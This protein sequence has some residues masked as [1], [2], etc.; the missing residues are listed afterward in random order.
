MLSS[1]SRTGKGNHGGNGV[2]GKRVADVVTCSDHDV[3][4]AGRQP[5]FLINFRNEQ[6]ARNRRITAG[7]YDNRIP[8]SE[9]RPD[10]TVREIHGGIPWADDPNNPNG[11]PI[12]AAL[13]S[14]FVDGQ[15]ASR[16][17]MR[18]RSCLKGY[19]LKHLP[20]ELGLDARAACLAYEPVDDLVP[21]FTHDVGG[22]E[23]NRRWFGRKR[24]C[25]C[26]RRAGCALVSLVDIRLIG[27]SDLGDGLPGVGIK[28]LLPMTTVAGPPRA[29][30]VLA[31]KTCVTKN[32]LSDI[33]DFFCKCFLLGT[34][35][36]VASRGSVEQ[37]VN[38]S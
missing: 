33:F 22:P 19:R 15:N 4:H 27:K 35:L 28:V 24:S 3:Q 6:T 31:L 13:C 26:G 7:F 36:L 1:S 16:H 29:V 18:K 2:L 34:H 20:L 9:R 37:L 12:N 5:G 10:R 11:L 30:N 23:H 25:P 8:Q 14:G 17:A 38:P 21:P 32:F